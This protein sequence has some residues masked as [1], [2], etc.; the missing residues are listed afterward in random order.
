MVNASHFKGKHFISMRDYNREELDFILDTAD[1]MVELEKQGSDLC[2]SK[3][4]ASMFFEPSTRTRLSF[5]T[6][7]FRLG[8]NVTTVADPKTSSAAKGETLEDTIKTI[9]NYA[10]IIAMRHP[11]NDAAL[12][13]AKVAMVPYINGGSG[14]WEHPTQTM[15]DLHCIRYAKG[16]MD[17]LTIGMVGD[18]KHGRTVHSLLLAL[19]HYDVKVK[20]I[21]P[22]QLKMKPD[23]IEGTEGK[24]EI[25]EV[26]DLKK[27]L[28]ELDLIYMTRVQ[29]ERFPD[30]ADY[31]KVKNSYILDKALLSKGKRDVVVMHPL[32]RVNEIATDIDPLPNAWYFRQVKHGIYA[33]M[34]IMG[35]ALGVL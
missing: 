6:A 22:E 1:Q 32:P 2:K 28:P 4:L 33:R 24:I 5:E 15:L 19:R 34:A 11:D 8:G 16:G 27:T 23:V 30:P 18:L 3:V 9:Q 25:E 26:T 31:D 35:L 21:A 17:G 20:L 10:D 12:R 29:K 13:A 14:S 7:M